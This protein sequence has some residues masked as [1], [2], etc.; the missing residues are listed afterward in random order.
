[1]DLNNNDA[2]IHN[3]SLNS[4]VNYLQSGFNHGTW[5]GS[6]II[7]STAAVNPTL[8]ALGVELNA[9]Q[10][11]T[12]GAYSTTP[13]LTQW[14]GITVALN[15][16]LVQYTLVGDADLSGNIT[17]FDYS[18]ID[19]GYDVNQAY[20][21]AHPGGT[22]PP[23]TGWHNGDFNYDGVINGDDYS[24][25]DNSYNTEGSTSINSSVGIPIEPADMIASDTEQ[26][27]VPEPAATTLLAIALP[28]LLR[29]RRRRSP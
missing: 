25:I 26:I 3:N 10:N 16:V 18:L 24:L 11:L 5:S 1:L 29:R 14:Q 15:D 28:A 20:Y 4:I 19:N 22:S 9:T 17:I 23:L 27:S 7:S 13:A 2:D 12:T 6:G 8:R 21:A